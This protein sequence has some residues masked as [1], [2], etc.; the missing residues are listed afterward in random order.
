MWASMRLYDTVCEPENN[1]PSLQNSLLVSNSATASS[2]VTTRSQQ[3]GVMYMM[4]PQVDPDI[5]ATYLY[6]WLYESEAWL[7]LASGVGS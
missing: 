4:P 3:Q 5:L 1:C 7:V 2:L 6:T